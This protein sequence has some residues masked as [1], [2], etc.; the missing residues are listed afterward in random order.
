MKCFYLLYSMIYLTLR[1][2]A[3]MGAKI[4]MEILQASI[5]INAKKERGEDFNRA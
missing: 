1:V 3:W 5:N 2:S 4:G